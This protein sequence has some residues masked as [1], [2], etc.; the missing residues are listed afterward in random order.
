M[1]RESAK[2]LRYRNHHA[3]N[4]ALPH[5]LAHYNHRRPHSSLD[6]QP[7]TS[8]AHNLTGQDT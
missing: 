2:G 8:R 1:E 7:P 3:R 4:A 6:G 5:R